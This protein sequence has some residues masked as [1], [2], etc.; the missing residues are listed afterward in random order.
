MKTWGRIDGAH[1]TIHILSDGTL[2]GDFGALVPGLEVTGDP[3]GQEEAV[4]EA[5]APYPALRRMRAHDF[6]WRK[7]VDLAVCAPAGQ[8][9]QVLYLDTDVLVRRPVRLELRADAPLTYLR[10][11]V[12]SYRGAWWA[13][14][15]EPMVLSFNSGM[16]A[17]DPA[18][19]DLAYLEQAVRRYFRSTG[20]SWWSEQMA[21]SLLAGRTRGRRIW[22]G[23]HARVVCGFG[24]RTDAEMSADVVKHF[25]RHRYMRTADEMRA[26]TGAAEVIHMAGMS[27]KFYEALLP[28]SDEGPPVPVP[29]RPDPLLGPLERALVAGRLAARRGPLAAVGRAVRSRFRS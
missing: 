25:A 7:I 1:P 20:V 19:V 8:G 17:V 15:R 9:D 3:G 21:W 12:P 24:M 22:S 5:L 13:P 6:T 23:G 28:G 26:F 4:A 18:V 10:E 14:F 27:K 16:V 11:D 29:S 2:D